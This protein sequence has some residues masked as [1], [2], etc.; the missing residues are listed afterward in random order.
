MSKTLIRRSSFMGAVLAAFS[1][2]LAFPSSVSA[3]SSHYPDDPYTAG[4]LSI[5]R[6]T[7]CYIVNGGT[8][9]CW[10][11]NLE[12]Q[13]GDPSLANVARGNDYTVAGINN[14]VAVSVA[15]YHACALLATGEVKCWGSQQNGRL[16]NGESADNKVTTPVVLSG[17]TNAVD[18][19]LTLNG[20]CVITLDRTVKCWGYNSFGEVGDGTNT[21]KT[22]PVP[23]SVTNPIRLV[24]IDGM[25]TC[26]ITDGASAATSDNELWCWGNNGRINTNQLITTGNTNDVLSPTLI[27][28]NATTPLQGVVAASSTGSSMCA[29]LDIGTVWCWGSNN[30]GRLGNGSL[31]PSPEPYPVQVMIASAT[32]VTGAVSISAI[33]AATCVM[34]VNSGTKAQRCWGVAGAQPN[35]G[36]DPN[37]KFAD[38]IPIVSAADVAYLSAAETSPSANGQGIDTYWCAIMTDKTLKCGNDTQSTV[39]PTLSAAR[40]I[41]PAP[42]LAQPATDTNSN[43]NTNSSTNTNTESNT[44]ATSASPTKAVSTLPKTG[45][46]SYELFSL[47]VFMLLTGTALVGMKKRAES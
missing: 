30:G 40:L 4:M 45:D 19:E 2:M 47:A 26:V 38:A 35:T 14:A 23:V 32:P 25:T 8:V 12:G 7:A 18:V 22:T 6:A 46:T 37:S 17:I 36:A 27:K 28:A 11:R 44:A 21:A 20:G 3:N 13:A 16:G 34:T 29:V 1:L 15:T 5:G 42:W 41:N 24:S 31:S 33:Q 43:A 39:S 9:K 10:G